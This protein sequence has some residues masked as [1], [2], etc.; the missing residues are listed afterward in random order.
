MGL[1]K[2]TKQDANEE[3]RELGAG[4]VEEITEA[5]CLRGGAGGIPGSPGAGAGRRQ[6]RIQSS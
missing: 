4:I 5:G 6:G 1:V 3:V 2:E